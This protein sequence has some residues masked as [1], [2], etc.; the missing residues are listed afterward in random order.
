MPVIA[1]PLEDHLLGRL[2]GDAAEVLGRDVAL[3]DL[4]AVFRQRLLRDLGLLGLPKLA[5]LRVDLGLL[6]LLLHL[7]EQLLLEVRGH[8]QLVDL[9]VT[10]VVVDLHARVLRSAGSLLVGG[11][12]SVLESLHQPVGGD[13]LLSL[14]HRDGVED[15]LAHRPSSTRLLR[16]ISEYG[17]ETTP[18]SAATVTSSSEAP[19][20][21]PVKLPRPWRGLRVRTRARRPR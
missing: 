16:P 5:R 7:R 2:G 11:Q 21:S 14:Q 6:L 10:G 8:Q 3:V 9:E 15:L 1:D 17:I 13:S 18:S 19:T 12:Q 20:S 4:I